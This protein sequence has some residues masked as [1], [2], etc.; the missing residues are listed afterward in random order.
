M[1]GL[2]KKKFDPA[3]DRDSIREYIED[4]LKDRLKVEPGT[5][6]EVS[7]LPSPER[8]ARRR[9]GFGRGRDFEGFFYP[10]D[11]KTSEGDDRVALNDLLKKRAPIPEMTS[12]DR[13]PQTRKKYGFDV[14]V[15]RA[16]DMRTP[17]DAWTAEDLRA[18]AELLQ[19]IHSITDATG[20][21]SWSASNPSAEYLRAVEK[22]WV[23]SLETA[24][25]ALGRRVNPVKEAPFREKAFGRLE[26]AGRYELV[27]G[28]PTPHG[29]QR[30]LSGG[31]IVADFSAF[32]FGYREWDLAVLEQSFFGGECPASRTLMEQYLKEAAPVVH[33]RLELLKPFFAGLYLLEQMVAGIPAT[34][35]ASKASAPR[36]STPADLMEASARRANASKLW[37]SFLAATG[38]PEK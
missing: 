15:C 10:V 21:R 7:P 13:T 11:K 2:F 9:I 14:V 26:N 36:K 25:T 32:H 33:K 20:G 6:A 5:P 8:F 29:F 17:E 23:Q 28:A 24:G 27:H 3:T 12:E 4:V 18:L 16:D 35:S 30:P 22:R 31:V 38:L 34:A 1:F 19:K 37:D